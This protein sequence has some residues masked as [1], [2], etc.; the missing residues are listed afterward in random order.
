MISEGAKPD[1]KWAPYLAVLP[2]QLD[3]L[4]FWTDSEIKELQA[5]AVVNKIEK[6]KAEAMFSQHIVP[7]ELENSNTELCHQVASVIMAYA[8]D[9]PEK[10]VDTMN[11]DMSHEQDGDDLVSDNEEDEPT[12]LS[13]IPLADMLNAD[14]DRN[15]VRLCC[16]NEDLEMRTIKPI[17]NGQE[18]FN[19]YGSLPRSDL[20]RR[21]GYITNEYAIYDVV[22][23]STEN[24][25]SLF[26]RDGQSGNQEFQLDTADLEKRIALCQREDVYDESYDLRRSGPDGPSIPDE[27]LAMLFI[28]LLNEESLAKLSSSEMYVPS[29]SKIETELIG[30][31]LGTLLGQREKE[32]A[33]TIEEDAA[34]LRAENLPHRTRMAI[35]VR[36]GEKLVLQDALR[37]SCSYSGSSKYMRDLP[38]LEKGPK[39]SAEESSHPNKKGRFR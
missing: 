39:R 33:T 6:A 37:E 27:M 22:E 23:I 4:V 15:N 35:Q 36:F 38:G 18:L 21:Y 12:V 2:Q 14:A 26:K 5:S 30:L 19:D 25:I 34:L 24:L 31:V 7:L 1:S 28:L 10:V 17:R 32:Y 3:S 16:D 20:L 29:R 8:F 13:M 9:I 11:G